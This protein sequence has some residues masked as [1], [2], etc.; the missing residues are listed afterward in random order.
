[1]WM[2]FEETLFSNLTVCPI[3]SVISYDF[4]GTLVP[5]IVI[6]VCAGTGKTITLF[7]DNIELINNA[8]LEVFQLDA[9]LLSEF[10]S[11]KSK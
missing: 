4:I 6:M 1:M 7:S 11:I 5:L 10:K 3:K 8:L 2:V 9:S